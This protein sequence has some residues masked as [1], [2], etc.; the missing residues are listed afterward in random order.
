MGANRLGLI[1]QGTSCLTFVQKNH[2]VMVKGAQTDIESCIDDWEEHSY[3]FSFSTKVTFGQQQGYIKI[4]EERI[5]QQSLQINT[6][7][8]EVG[9]LNKQ[10]DENERKKFSLE[11]FKDDD[12]AIQLYTG[13]PNY[14]ALM[15]VYEYLDP[16]VSKLQC[17][18]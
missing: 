13:F 17:W 9:R 8:Q 16:K 11:N 5:E 3:S 10:L 7:K 4:L 12:S 18:T 2:K 6:L 14:K 15:A 1:V